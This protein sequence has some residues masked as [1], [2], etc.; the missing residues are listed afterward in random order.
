MTRFMHRVAATSAHAARYGGVVDVRVL[1]RG[2]DV[3]LLEQ[4]RLSP[5]IHVSDG[6]GGAPRPRSVAGLK[7][8]T[9]TLVGSGR[10]YKFWRFRNRVSLGSFALRSADQRR[11]VSIWIRISFDRS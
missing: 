2:S 9:T 6:D 7:G 3:G 5:G 8:L 1:D 4:P 10:R 11:C